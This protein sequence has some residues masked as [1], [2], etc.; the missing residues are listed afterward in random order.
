MRTA[1][2]YIRMRPGCTAT[3]ILRDV[4]PTTTQSANTYAAVRALEAGGLISRRPH[5]RDPK[6]MRCYLTAEGARSI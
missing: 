6:K 1:L 3:D 4:A 2:E 5:P